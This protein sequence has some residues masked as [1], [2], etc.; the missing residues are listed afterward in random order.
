VF[1]LAWL[2]QD[3]QLEEEEAV[4]EAEMEAVEEVG[5]VVEVVERNLI[6]S[7]LK[8]QKWLL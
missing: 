7:N 4:E 2:G 3:Q 5:M 1:I 8:T 6:K